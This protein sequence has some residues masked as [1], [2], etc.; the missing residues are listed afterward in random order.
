MVLKG[1]S[2][3]F[4]VKLD[5]KEDI[6][7]RATC[8][9]TRH[10]HPVMETE[11]QL[12]PQKK[13]HSCIK[14][15]GS[16]SRLNEVLDAWAERNSM[17]L[18]RPLAP[19]QTLTITFPPPC[20]TMGMNNCQSIRSLCVKRPFFPPLSFTFIPTSPP[21]WVK[22]KQSGDFRDL[23]AHLPRLAWTSYW[24]MAYA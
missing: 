19:E 14:S 15:S 5:Q 8:T 2:L 17:V 16:H 22:S 13:T 10:L 18:P 11:Y 7:P 9:N 6:P 12:K 20:L 3:W 23:G 4:L 1:A 21:P 24:N